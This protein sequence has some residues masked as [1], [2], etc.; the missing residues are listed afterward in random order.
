MSY[1]NLIE[2]A[3]ALFQTEKYPEAAEKYGEAKEEAPND[4]AKKYYNLQIST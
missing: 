2:E 3:D 4:Q 1:K